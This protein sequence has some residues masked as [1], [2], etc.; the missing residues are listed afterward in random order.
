MPNINRNNLQSLQNTT[1]QVW[2]QI[3][4]SLV[5]F[6]TRSY[7]IFEKENASVSSY[8]FIEE[9][10]VHWEC[11]EVLLSVIYIHVILR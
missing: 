8:W 6:T 7:N 9:T 4:T 1:S 11:A 3:L 10:K 2:Q 5:V